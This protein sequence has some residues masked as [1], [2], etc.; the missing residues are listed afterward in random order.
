MSRVFPDSQ[1]RASSNAM[2]KFAPSTDN[3]ASVQGSHLG[4]PSDANDVAVTSHVPEFADP[5]SSP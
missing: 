1:R 5:D 2:H 4:N 3:L